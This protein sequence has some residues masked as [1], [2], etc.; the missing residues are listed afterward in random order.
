M[1]QLKLILQLENL[2]VLK[3]IN[4][5]PLSA[6]I[7]WSPAKNLTELEVVHYEPERHR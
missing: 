2:K 3:L 1:G 4:T 7:D 5:G 6:K